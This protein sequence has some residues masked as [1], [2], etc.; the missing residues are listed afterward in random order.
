[1][2]MLQ[3]CEVAYREEQGPKRRKLLQAQL[4]MTVYR[5]RQRAARQITAHKK[6]HDHYGKHDRGILQF[7]DQ[8]IFENWYLFIYNFHRK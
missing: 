1:M 3:R 8:I 4:W 6:I 7:V 5:G 2:K